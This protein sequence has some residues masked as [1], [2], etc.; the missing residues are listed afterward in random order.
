MELVT[1]CF[2]ANE[3][4]SS[5]EEEAAQHLSCPTPHQVSLLLRVFEVICHVSG[6]GIRCGCFPKCSLPTGGHFPGEG[7][8]WMRWA[9]SLAWVECSSQLRH[10]S[11]LTQAERTQTGSGLIAQLSPRCCPC[12]SVWARVPAHLC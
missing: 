9:A 8:P 4:R 2:F 10:S 5:R 11:V 3:L 12:S 1:L 7:K 6:V